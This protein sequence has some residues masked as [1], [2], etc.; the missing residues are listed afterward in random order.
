M[1]NSSRSRPTFINRSRSAQEINK[2]KTVKTNEAKDFSKSEAELVDVMD[3]L[4]HAISVIEKEVA[5]NLV[6]LHMEIDTRNTNIATAALIMTKTSMSRAFSDQC[7]HAETLPPSLGSTSSFWK[8]CM[9]KTV[10]DVHNTTDDGRHVP[11]IAVR[12]KNE[13]DIQKLINLPRKKQI[14][15]HV[16][17][18]GCD[19]ASSNQENFDEI[20]NEMKN[21]SIKDFIGENTHIPKKI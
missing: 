11:K 8:R 20:S 5:K 21:M 10:E 17:K 9:L 6:F 7:V 1:N 12:L 19:T 18:M 3:T 15:I 14:C 13:K 4:Q 16:N 2:P